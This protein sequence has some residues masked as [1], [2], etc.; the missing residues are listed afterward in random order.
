MIRQSEYKGS[1]HQIMTKLWHLQV[2]NGQ[3]NKFC[4]VFKS[5]YFWRSFVK[6]LYYYNVFPGL[7]GYQHV[8]G[9]P[10]AHEFVQPADYGTSSSINPMQPNIS[11]QQIIV[12]GGCPECRVTYIW[13]FESK[14][15]IFHI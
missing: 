14:S 10:T 3:D 12:I 6:K 9:P 1:H 2:R 5:D 7:V 11:H 8:T 15:L 13:H 4:V